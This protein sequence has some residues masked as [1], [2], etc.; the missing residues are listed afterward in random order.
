MSLN[1]RK[2]E[3][4]L[5]DLHSAEGR[6]NSSEIIDLEKEI[7]TNEIKEKVHYANI[8]KENAEVDKEQSTKIDELKK[9][10]D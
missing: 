9:M 3:D 7:K 5:N 2:D 1:R 6:H 8:K 4:I 10:L